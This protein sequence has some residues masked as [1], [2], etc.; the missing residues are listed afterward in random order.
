MDKAILYYTDQKLHGGVAK[1]C[2]KNLRKVAGNIPIFSVSQG[3]L[4]FGTY[5]Y[6]IEEMERSR[7]SM[8][9]QIQYGLFKM[10]EVLNPKFVFFAE[11]DVLYPLDYFDF[12]PDRN[13]TFYYFIRKYFMNQKGF[14]YTGQCDLSTLA[15]NFKLVLAHFTLRLYRIM[16]LNMK[17]GGWEKSE[18]GTSR[19]D[20]TG[21][22]E[23]RSNKYPC[24]DVRHGNNISNVIEKPVLSNIEYWGFCEQIKKDM[25]WI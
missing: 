17:K 19:D 6:V 24:I 20:H 4:E 10:Y 13:D 8:Y 11:H 7:F 1:H 2:R 25:Q 14:W 3:E 16:Y 12:I 23:V 9:Q 21:L 15:G 5:N 22:W 18:P